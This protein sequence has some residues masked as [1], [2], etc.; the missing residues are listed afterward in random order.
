M[1]KPWAV[2]SIIVLLAMITLL[3]AGILIGQEDTQTIL[4]LMDVAC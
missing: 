1:M 3:L 4:R 2:W